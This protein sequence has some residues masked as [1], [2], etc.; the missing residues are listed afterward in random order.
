MLFAFLSSVFSGELINNLWN[1]SNKLLWF[2]LFLGSFFRFYNLTAKPLWTDEFATLVFSLGNNYHSIILDQLINIK[3]LLEPLKYNPQATIKDIFSLLITEDNH[4]P[5]YFILAHYWNNLWQNNNEYISIFTARSLSAIFGIISIPLS[6]FLAKFS[7]KNSIIANYL[8]WFIAVSAFGIYLAQEARHYTLAIIW[9]LISFFGLISLI[10]Y[11]AKNKLVPF[12]LISML[13]LTNLLGILTHYFFLIFLAIEII[14]IFLLI[15]SSLLSINT[16]LIVLPKNFIYSHN[17]KYWLTKEILLFSFL[18]Y[19]F[20]AIIP[21]DYGNNMTAWI[22][23]DSQN[24]MAMVSPIFQLL[25]TLITMV[26]LL[27]VESNNLIIVIISGLLMLLFFIWFIPLI[28]Q[29][30]RN[31]EKSLELQ[32]IKYICLYALII[33]LL[34]FFSI[35]YILG[36]DITRGARYS[37]V[38]FPLVITLLSLNLFSVEIKQKLTKPIKFIIALIGIASAVT[39]TSN[40]GYQKYYR[41]DLL[42]PVI[43]HYSQN[44]IVIAT[45]HQTLVQ[46]GEMM[47]I[48]HLIFQ[49]KTDNLLSK[50]QFILAHQNYENDPSASNILQANLS[51]INQPTDLW[52]VN[53]YAPVNLEK[54][55]GAEQNK[56]FPAIDGYNYQLYHCHS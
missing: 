39:V 26:V 47:G 8:A 42:I 46:T 50:T 11:F 3:Q 30:L 55:V 48:A 31:Q 21:P 51:K 49:D 41:P 25:A 43:K 2:S 40:L 37:F 6:Y 23:A 12:S 53:F 20:I 13:L 7:F 19:W 38:Y 54:C 9:V 5:L 34:I 10:K 14:V 44:Q 17:F 35:T 56:S 28:K 29:G 22:A 18:I 52:L 36:L 27:P 45:S 33:S 24:I 15:I 1:N 32:S 16:R 4:P